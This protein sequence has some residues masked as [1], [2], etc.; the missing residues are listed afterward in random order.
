[1]QDPGEWKLTSPGG[2]KHKLIR[3]WGSFGR[4]GAT[5]KQ[6]ICIQSHDLMAL[7]VES[8][9]VPYIVGPLVFYPRRFYPAGLPA[10]EC[11]NL[12]VEGFTSGRPVDPFAAGL[13]LYTS[14][15]YAA[16]FE[17][18]LRVTI[19]FGPSPANDQARDPDNLFTFLEITAAASG[20]FLTHEVNQD[21]VK[22]EDASGA[23]EDPDEKDT[24]LERSVVSTEVEW[25]CKWPQ[26]PF[27]FFYTVLKPRMH[28]AMGKVND[29]N[30][31]LIGNAPPETVLFLGYQMGY[32]YSWREGYT[33]VSPVHATLRFVEKN[34]LGPQKRA[35]GAW[36][37]T[38]VTHNHIFRSNHGWSRL[39][40]DDVPI[41]EQGNLMAIFTG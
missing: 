9:P 30:L 27:N 28:A 29:A 41:Y 20:E 4:E 19:T 26:I 18:Y 33:G 2:I 31:P 25:T 23:S 38:Q 39:L 13:A 35:S 24:D 8:F 3:Q 34:F 12:D 15:E 1:M 5:W 10:L 16:T 6:E 22:W 37:D 40:V 36:V 7:V 14:D 17:P 32:E 11:K 21:D